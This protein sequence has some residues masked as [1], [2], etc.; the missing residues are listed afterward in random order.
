MPDTLST[1]APADGWHALPDGRRLALTTYGVSSNLVVVL[2]H[3]GGQTRRS[4]R[5][6]ARRLADQGYQCVAIDLPGHGDS[7]RFPDGQYDL[8]RI[9]E[10]VGTCLATLAGEIVLVGSSMGGMVGLLLAAEGRVERLRS[11]VLVDLTPGFEAE[12]ANRAA[13]FMGSGTEGFASPEAAAVAVA[14]YLPHREPPS[15]EALR[16]HLRRENGRWYWHWDPGVL[17]MRDHMERL[18]DQLY[19]AAGRIDEPV[20]LVRGGNSDFVSDDSVADML[21]V[22]PHAEV[23]VVHGAT[24]MV[25]G[26]DN[27]AFGA[28]IERHLRHHSDSRI[29][30]ADPEPS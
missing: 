6:T 8:D 20:L 2:L 22:L 14:E 3:G 10:D 30:A 23:A 7:S 17:T 26:D 29:T 5:T 28:I 12:G 15:V 11:L 1:T 9:A 25:A 4:W 27:D 16:D 19:R 24:H 18:R 21:N 13:D